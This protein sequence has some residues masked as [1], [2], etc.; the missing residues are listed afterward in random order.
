MA[1]AAIA[2]ESVS[3]L[4]RWEHALHPWSSFLIVP[5]FALANAGVRFVGVDIVEAVLSP[6]ALGSLRRPRGR[7]ARRRR[8]RNVGSRSSSTWDS[9]RATPRS[10]TL[11]VSASLPESGSP[12]R[13]S[14]PNSRSDPVPMPTCSP[15]RPRSASSSA[16]S[17][18][19]SSDSRTCACT[20]PKSAR[21]V[22]SRR[23]GTDR[24][25]FAPLSEYETASGGI[26]NGR[27]A[28]STRCRVVDRPSAAHPT[29]QADGRRCRP[30][31]RLSRGFSLSAPLGR[32]QPGAPVGAESARSLPV[33]DGGGRTGRAFRAMERLAFWLNLYNA[34]ALALAADTLSAGENTVLRIP[35]AF[36]APWAMV[37]GESLSL[38][39]I[40]HGKIRRFGDPRIHAALVC[41]SASCPTLRYEPFGDNLECPTRQPDAVVPRRRWCATHRSRPPARFSCHE[42]SSGTAGISCALHVCPHGSRLEDGTSHE[43]SHNG[44]P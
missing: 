11:S 40:E 39:D 26:R 28:E 8:A 15:T 33:S 20:R 1:L 36:D 32:N 29:T 18:R 44:C 10:V 21:E 30:V 25:S 31:G 13:C 37:G 2:R 6:I 22:D 23:L 5:L 24:A 14:S 38:N 16:R 19:V 3:P 4:E 42:Y 43:R 7:Q 9:S 35:G 17:S 34:G 12:S 41:G 27:P